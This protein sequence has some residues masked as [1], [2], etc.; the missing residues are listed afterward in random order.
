MD[1]LETQAGCERQ[2]PPT[3][4]ALGCGA[5]GASAGVPPSVPEGADAAQSRVG[6]A[7]VTVDQE[8]FESGYGRLGLNVFPV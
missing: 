5:S 1:G 2:V 7:R 6:P 3:H 4:A 8:A